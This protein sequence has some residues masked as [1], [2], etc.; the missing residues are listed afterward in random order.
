MRV[1][2][3]APFSGP[4]GPVGFDDRLDSVPAIALVEH[5]H[6]GTAQPFTLRHLSIRRFAPCGNRRQA[7]EVEAKRASLDLSFRTD[8]L[9]ATPA[10][11][12]FGAWA[13]AERRLR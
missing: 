4:P 3:L 11:G 6:G 12:L 5:R 7:P 13:P 8:I 1:S 9:S 10:T 2:V